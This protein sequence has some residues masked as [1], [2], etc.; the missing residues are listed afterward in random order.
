MN[1][2]LKMSRT[3][4]SLVFIAA[5]NS[6]IAEFDLPASAFETVS[7]EGK[8]ELLPGSYTV[9]ALDAALLSVS[10]KK[11]ASAPV[12]AKIRVNQH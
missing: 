9:I 7:S 1:L 2:L 12:T 5:G 6:A 3:P 4:Y 8:F 10:V 11:G